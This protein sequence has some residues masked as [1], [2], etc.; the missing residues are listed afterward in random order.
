VIAGISDED[1]AYIRRHL[2]SERRHI[3]LMRDGRLAYNAITHGGLLAQ[4]RGSVGAIPARN[5][6]AYMKT[7]GG[8]SWLPRSRSLN[9]PRFQPNSYVR[10]SKISSI[11]A[12]LS[13]AAPPQRLLCSWGRV[14]SR[15]DPDERQ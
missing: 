13:K 6:R 15:T 3:L 11:P 5:R 1:S 10:Y 4:Q 14:V 9:T 7:M 2:P 8:L 12:L